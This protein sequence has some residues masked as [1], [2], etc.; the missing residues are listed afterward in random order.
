MQLQCLAVH[1]QACCRMQSLDT[2]LSWRGNEQHDA[3]ARL[4]GDGRQHAF[5]SD[6]VLYDDIEKMIAAKAGHHVLC[7]LQPI[8]I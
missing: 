7:M 1:S 5:A 2:M 6:L 4:D 3:F 8:G